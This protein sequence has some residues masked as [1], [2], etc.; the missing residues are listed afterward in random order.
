MI[1]VITIATFLGTLVAVLLLF[2]IFSSREASN[3]ERR[4]ESR[5]PERVG[6]E[7][8]SPDEPSVIEI[9]LTENVAMLANQMI[10]VN[11]AALMFVSQATLTETSSQQ[12]DDNTERACKFLALHIQE[13]DAMQRLK[14]KAGR[15]RV[16]VEH[17]NVHAGGQ[18]IVGT[19]T[20][21]E[22]GQGAGDRADNE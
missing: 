19:V 4:M 16:T 5:T 1:W 15:Q 22:A 14:G 6:M 10:A 17:V 9:S 12:R 18:A 2:F 13:V 21:R 7:L 8:Y 3:S 11:D 20:A